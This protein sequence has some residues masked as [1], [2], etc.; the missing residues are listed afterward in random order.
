MSSGSYVKWIAR[1][2]G[3]GTDVAAADGAEQSFDL[4]ERGVDQARRLAGGELVLQFE[5]HL[6]G[7]VGPP[8]PASW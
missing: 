6:I 1:R 2:S 3:A 4:V 5:E 7:G 8:S